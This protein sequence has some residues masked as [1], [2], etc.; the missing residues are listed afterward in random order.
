MAGAGEILVT[1]GTAPVADVGAR[2]ARLVS[3]GI[4]SPSFR[5]EGLSRLANPVRAEAVT[6]PVAEAFPVPANR[7]DTLI[8]GRAAFVEAVGRLSPD[9]AGWLL[10]LVRHPLLPAAAGLALGLLGILPLGLPAKKGAPA[11]MI[12]GIGAF[13]L[14][15]STVLLYLFQA[16]HGM[17]FSLVGVMLGTFMTG[18]AAGAA[19]GTI[20]PPK[21]RG[22]PFLPSLGLALTASWILFL[23]PRGLGSSLVVTLALVF[24]VGFLDGLA[25]PLLVRAAGVDSPVRLY[26]AEVAG[27]A[28]GSFIVA[29]L[30]LPLAGPSAA[31]GVVVLL[32]LATSLPCLVASPLRR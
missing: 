4:E 28:V 5:P 14:V 20:S 23:A 18:L 19:V 1:A 12:G 16:R 22:A 9:A 21:W 24:S 10:L 13:S 6:R 8:A 26:A 7:D 11:A 25:Y 31:I 30:V 3:R 32:L 2:R 29:A 27:A 17:L 15:T